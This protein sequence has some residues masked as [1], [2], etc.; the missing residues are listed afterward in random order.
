MAFTISSRGGTN[1]NIEFRRNDQDRRPPSRVLT[2]KLMGD[3]EPDRLAKAEAIR[4]AISAPSER[5]KGIA[6]RDGPNS[7]PKNRRVTRQLADEDARG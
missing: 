3:P 4:A 2:P 1:H 6:R 7:K 5:G